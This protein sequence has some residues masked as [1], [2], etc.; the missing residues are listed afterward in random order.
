M[1][2]F[3]WLMEPLCNN[4]VVLYIDYSYTF[5]HRSNLKIAEPLDN[6]SG[7]LVVLGL[8]LVHWLWYAVWV[9]V[10]FRLIAL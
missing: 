5:I 1:E 7:T 10:W 4:L 3:H 8:G 9:R 2:T 6:N